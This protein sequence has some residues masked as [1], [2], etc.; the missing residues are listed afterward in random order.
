MM[1]SGM[2]VDEPVLDDVL[3]QYRTALAIV[4]EA[5]AEKFPEYSMHETVTAKANNREDGNLISAIGVRLGIHVG[6]ADKDAL[7]PHRDNPVVAS[8]LASRSAKIYCDYLQGV[9]D[10]LR[11]G[12]I[13][14]G[15]RQCAAQGRGR[16]TS[17]DAAIPSVNLQNP[18]NPSK[19]CAEMR[20]FNLPPVRSVFKVPEG[21]AM[22]GTDYSAA[23]ARIAAETTK[24]KAFI[25]SYIDN[26]DIHCVVASKLS[27]LVD[28]HWT[29]EQITK[30]R[31][32]KTEDGGLATRL[33]NTSKN[34]FYGWLNGAGKAKTAE[35][36]GL[37]GF[38]CTVE[39]AG[40]IIDLLGRAF[41]GIKQYHD[42]IKRLIM[43]N[44]VAF[45]GCKTPYVAVSGV[46]GRRVW[47][48]VW[49][50][51]DRGYGGAK[52]T[53]ALMVA[54]MTVESDAKKMAMGLVR[55]R[56]AENPDW[57]LRL[58]NDCHDELVWV[59][60]EEHFNAAGEAVWMAMQSTLAYFVKKIPV[61]EDYFE[62][63][64]PTHS[65]DECK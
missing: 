12:S 51:D 64:K 9:K 4:G 21:Y 23:H 14:G 1:V 62:P 37:G 30:I 53:D 25:S 60:K 31:K 54:W 32:E 26:V 27:T 5:F 38:G 19:M 36:I 17:G 56:S 6:K 3:Q 46:S 34:V 61:Y 58:V 65:W 45:D 55:E 41:P 24:D 20:V 33:R 13:R 49:P 2:P 35:T 15:Y 7:N 57:C 40:E 10:S 11:E 29:Q 22:G 47:L 43:K 18:P 16:S 28:K 59:A 44:P 42:K 52:P 39:F 48:P 8:L 50:K 63:T